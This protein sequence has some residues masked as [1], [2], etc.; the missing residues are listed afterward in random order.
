MCSC[1]AP[2]YGTIPIPVPP[3]YL[4]Y[5]TIHPKTK[6]LGSKPS[7]GKRGEVWF[8]R[9]GGERVRGREAFWISVCCLNNYNL[10]SCP[11]RYSLFISENCRQQKQQLSKGVEDSLSSL[12]IGRRPFDIILDR[13][14]WWY[15][16]IPYIDH[17]Y[18]STIPP[19]ACRQYH[20]TQQARDLSLSW[21]VLLCRLLHFI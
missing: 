8:R 19:A 7:L 2:P 6:Q 11:I 4:H 20:T 5:I 1:G 9:V 18:H 14:E 10:L 15:P 16:T 3:P 17:G 13:L 21:I 12:R